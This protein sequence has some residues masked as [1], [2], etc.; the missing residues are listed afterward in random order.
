MQYYYYDVSGDQIE[1]N[2]Q[3]AGPAPDFKLYEQSFGGDIYYKT[4]EGKISEV[5]LESSSKDIS[6]K[7]LNLFLSSIK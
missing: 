3:V 7:T 6:R 1:F 5:I 4:K 2:G